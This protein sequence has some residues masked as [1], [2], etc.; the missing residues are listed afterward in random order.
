MS[1]IISV[2][3]DEAGQERT[4]NPH[5]KWYLLTLV[6]HDQD[7][8][9][10]RHVD[11]YEGY[12]RQ[13]GLPDV[14]FHMV[15]LMH[16]HGGYTGLSLADRKRLLMSFNSLVQRLPVGYC[17]F[18]YRRSEFGDY[19]DLSARMERDLKE[20]IDEHLA[21]F[22]GYGTAAVYYDGGQ[23]AVNQAVHHAF[24]ENLSANVAEYKKLRYQERRL[25]QV[26][27]YL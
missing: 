19:Q 17:T 5:A 27:D 2:F 16:G 15:D 25:A 7:D 9:I 11:A 22:Q 8:D 20:F 18:A 12:I 13:K 21:E 24:D 14:P 26:A 1:K 6:L 4:W 23:S 3:L 10:T